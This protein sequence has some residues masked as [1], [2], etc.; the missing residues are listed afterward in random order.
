MND[1]TFKPF[2]GESLS[3][4]RDR[5]IY[6]RY[7][8]NN[9]S[10]VDIANFMSMY[11]GG[12]FSES[13][14]RKHWNAH[15]TD[16]INKC[17]TMPSCNGISSICDCNDVVDDSGN[18]YTDAL[19][20]IRKERVKLS[21]ERTQL[22]AF[23]RTI[24]REETLKEIAIEAVK[25]LSHDKVLESYDVIGS[26]GNSAILLLSDWHYGIE[27]NNYWN[28]Y[29]PDVAESRL[30]ELLSKV[31][32]YC[33]KHSVTDINVVNLSDLISG[34]IH[35]QIRIQNRYDLITQTMKVSEILAEFLVNL[36]KHF[37]V[38]YYDCD[39]NHSRI[40]PNKKESLNIES[41]SRIIKWYL[42][43]RLKDNNN[44]IINDNEYSDDIITF[45][46]RFGHNIAG[47]HGD[48][49]S[50]SAV[51][52]NISLLTHDSYDLILTAHLH[53][54]YCNSENGTLVVSNGSLMGTDDY[55][56]KIRKSSRASQTLIISSD[57]NVAECIYKIDLE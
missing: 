17:I 30:S 45:V 2:D 36:S 15:K 28:I 6:T 18:S 13:N 56:Q 29:N 32:S 7:I 16:I 22:N 20:E 54:F 41:M 47:V 38:Q 39:D 49:D 33:D 10:W 46:D 27:V 12:D 5:L 8:T 35:L 26:S 48:R 9:I 42:K 34:I 4:Y 1:S 21:D 52:K 3:D 43:E 50:Q 24:S 55:A 11:F 31:I 14:P 37:N 19:L 51:I 57:E 23:V 40:S 53:H 25:M 44:I